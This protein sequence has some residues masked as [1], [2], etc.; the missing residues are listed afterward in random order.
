MEERGGEEEV[1]LCMEF[2]PLVSDGGAFFP[3]HKQSIADIL[4]NRASTSDPY[5]I[6]RSTVTIPLR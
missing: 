2:R 1:N 3:R 4:R 5:I 6:S